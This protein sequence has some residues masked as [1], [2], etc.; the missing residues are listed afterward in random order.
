MDVMGWPPAT[1]LDHKDKGPYGDSRSLG[2]RWLCRATAFPG[3]SASRFLLW[4]RKIN[5]CM[6]CATFIWNFLSFP[7]E[8]APYC[9]ASTLLL[10]LWSSLSSRQSQGTLSFWSLASVGSGSTGRCDSAEPRPHTL[11][12]TEREFQTLVEGKWMEIRFSFG[13]SP[14]SNNLLRI[15]DVDSH[16]G[17]WAIHISGC[18]AFFFPLVPSPSLS[19]S[20]CLPPPFLALSF[21]FLPSFFPSWSRT[22]LC[23]M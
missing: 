23:E 10:S 3:L 15:Q 14:S 19:P 8:P 12:D 18:A 4:E 13:K 2:S 6:T 16:P 21:F 22:C 11:R 1:A 20:L 17:A 9:Y 5:L 7:D